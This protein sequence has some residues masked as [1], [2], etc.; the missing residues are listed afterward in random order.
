MDNR[1]TKMKSLLIIILT[2]L[3]AIALLYV[4]WAKIR[5]LFHS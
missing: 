3:M 1:H 2:W 4:V 5:I